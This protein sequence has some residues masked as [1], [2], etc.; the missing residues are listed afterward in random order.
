MRSVIIGYV[1]G[2]ALLVL[3]GILAYVEQRPS[4]AVSE[5]TGIVVDVMNDRGMYYPIVRFQAST[6]DSI[7]FRSS[8][9]ATP[10]AYDIGESVPVRY[11]RSN[12]TNAFIVGFVEQWLI[13][14]VVAVLGVV[15]IL[16]ARF[17][18]GDHGWSPHVTPRA[19]LVSGTLAIIVAVLLGGYR[20]V[21]GSDSVHTTST[22]VAVELKGLRFYPTV[23]YRDNT[24]TERRVVLPYGSNPPT[25]S[26]GEAVEIEYD[27]QHPYVASTT[28]WWSRYTLALIPGITGLVLLFIGAIL[29]AVMPKHDQR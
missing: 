15:T 13:I 6:R 2:S 10:P 21:A 29:R 5:T 12:P 16:I 24:G 7:T 27:P 11:E 3:A 26:V 9:G 8:V 4:D 25:F 20:F 28:S 14:L 22:V 23:A 1:L 18:L 19:I 17:L